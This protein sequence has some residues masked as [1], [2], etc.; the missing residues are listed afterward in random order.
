MST[1]AYDYAETPAPAGAPLVVAFHGTGGDAHQFTDLLRELAPGAHLIAP[2]GDVSERGALRYFKRTGEG[3]YDMEDLHLR[4]EKMAGF[5]K[6]QIARIK[7]ARVIGLGYSN[8]ANILASVMFRDAVFFDEAV[9][10]H[11]L[12]PFEP[13][14]NAGLAA[15]R[16]L[17]TAGRNDPICPAPLTQ[18]LADYLEAQGSDLTLDWHEGGHE[19]RHSELAA[20]RNFFTTTPA[21][22]G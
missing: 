22:A 15:A 11:P 8:G 12:I 13:A 14:P 1:N 17:I 18:A 4:T 16:I 6:A 5:L 20:L 2:R 19:L 3:V 9:L 7:P 21:L 10:M